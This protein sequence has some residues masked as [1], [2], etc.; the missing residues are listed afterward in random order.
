MVSAAHF[1]GIGPERDV[2]SATRHADDLLKHFAASS[3]QAVN[4]HRI[5]VKLTKAAAEHR[6]KLK[7]D[8]LISR[9]VAVPHLFR[10][11]SDESPT[12]P[13]TPPTADERQPARSWNL[14]GQPSESTDFLQQPEKERPHPPMQNNGSS[15]S[16]NKLDADTN[17]N[18]A[19]AQMLVQS[20]ENDFVDTSSTQALTSDMTYE[21]EM[22]Y[23]TLLCLGNGNDILDFYWGGSL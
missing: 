12:S 6:D 11:R 2:E 14:W 20:Y 5:V 10:L 8:D 17:Y 1:G 13:A 4:Y 3:P 7:N 19:D 15:A 22:E 9:A 21:M 18:Y 16:T 23:D